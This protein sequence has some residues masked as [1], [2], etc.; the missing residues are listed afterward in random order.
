MSHKVY[1]VNYRR[2]LAVFWAVSARSCALFCLWIAPEIS[3]P[4]HPVV[5]ARDSLGSPRHRTHQKKFTTY[6][7]PHF[8]RVVSPK[9][10]IPYF[11][12][13]YELYKLY[14]SNKTKRNDNVFHCQMIIDNI[15]AYGKES[16]RECC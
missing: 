5:P 8:E 15:L 7:R 16:A 1:Y 10:Y 14:K 3:L 2:F 13:L 4:H 9:K 11:Y 6:P 12:K